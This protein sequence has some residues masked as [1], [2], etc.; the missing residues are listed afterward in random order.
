MSKWII[1]I[2]PSP[3]DMKKQAGLRIKKTNPTNSATI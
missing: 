1:V 2:G 3:K